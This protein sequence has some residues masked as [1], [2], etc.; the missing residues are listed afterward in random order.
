MMESKALEQSVLMKITPTPEDNKRIAKVRTKIQNE[1]N[2]I[3]NKLGYKNIKS[4]LVGSVAKDTHLK[5][6]DLDIFIMFPPSTTR[7]DLESIGLKIGYEVLP[8]AVELYAEH[9]YLRGKYED[10]IIDLVPCYDIKSSSEKLSAVDRTPFHTEYVKSH[11]QDIL[12]PDVRLFK[13]FLKG[14]GAYGAEIRVQGFSGYLCEVLV[15]EFGGFQEVIKA[16]IEWQINGRTI[17]IP[18]NIKNDFDYTI[19][20]KFNEPLIVIDPIDVTRNVGSPVSEDTI[21]LVHRAAESYV[22]SP[23]ERFFFPN[24]PTPKTDVELKGDIENLPGL[25]LGLE[26]KTKPEV[27]DILYS[28]VRKSLRATVKVLERYDFPV[29]RSKFFV[30][31]SVD[32]DNNTKILFLIL[33]DCYELPKTKVHNG[34]PVNHPNESSFIE[35]WK[36]ANNTA[37]G[38]YQKDDWWF[39]EILREFISAVELLKAQFSSINHG[40][41]L[42]ESVLAGAY[43]IIEGPKLAKE[44]YSN[45]LTEFLDNKLPWEY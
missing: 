38:P 16:I 4:I 42:N 25:L 39:V 32:K 21:K 14:I 11:L 37:K 2:R 22:S 40:K 24:K 18:K 12:K 41:Q 36:D 43:K 44:E 7:D 34:P 20:A 13:Q 33:L 15:I 5:N 19:L 30:E 9:P 1:I 23:D 29:L 35:K 17:I 10:I 31:E 6:F 27:S 8:E 3:S 45:A 26:L 28:Q